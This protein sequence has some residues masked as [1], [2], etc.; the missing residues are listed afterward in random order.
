MTR[1]VQLHGTFHACLST[2]L[3][4]SSWKLPL[5]FDS[6]QNFISKLFD[7]FYENVKLFN[8]PTKNFTG[9]ENFC[10]NHCL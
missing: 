6:N 7:S 3:F 10:E 9:S 2:L 4:K 1:H 5:K 8:L